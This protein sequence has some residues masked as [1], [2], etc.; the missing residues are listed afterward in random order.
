MFPCFLCVQ[1]YNAQHICVQFML[2]C[3]LSLLVYIYTHN[4]ADVDGGWQPLVK[5]VWVLIDCKINFASVLSV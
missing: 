1:V 2:A 3:D 4:A 5:F